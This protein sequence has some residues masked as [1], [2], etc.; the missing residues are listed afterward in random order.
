M[1]SGDRPDLVD[2]VRGRFL[3]TSVLA[4]GEPFDGP[5]WEGRGDSGDD[6]RAYVCR[7]FTCDTPA[8]TPAELDERLGSG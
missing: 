2:A 7:N 4:W 8:T 3:P 6:G 5:L 1:I